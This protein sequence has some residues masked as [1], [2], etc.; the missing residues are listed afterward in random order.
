MKQYK[1]CVVG[2]GH[3]GLVA[4]A[5]F[6]EL[7]YSVVC[8][9][10]DKKKIE[11]LKKINLPF[12]EPDLEPLVKKNLKKNPPNNQTFIFTENKI[13]GVHDNGKFEMHWNGILEVCNDENGIYL[14]M[15]T[16]NAII[17]PAK[18]IKG[19]YDFN[20]V[21]ETLRAFHLNA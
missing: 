18:S 15:G 7:G 2:A 8:I 10:N 4:A 12:Y 14:Y 5:C 19:Q 3:V 21:L 1:I 17:L 16:E 13:I 11:A 6:A 20:D 9:D